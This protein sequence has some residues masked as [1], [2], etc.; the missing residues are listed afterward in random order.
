MYTATGDFIEHFNNEMGTSPKCPSPS[1]V[2]EDDRCIKKKFYK[3]WRI[4]TDISAC[5]DNEVFIQDK[6]Y[7]NINILK[8]NEVLKG[9][10]YLLSNNKEY[11]LLMQKDGHL[12]IYKNNKD[13]TDTVVWASKKWGNIKDKYKLI[14]QEDGNLVVYDETTPL[15]ASNTMQSDWNLKKKHY[16]LMLLDSGILVI[17][18]GSN[19]IWSSYKHIDNAWIDYGRNWSSSTQDECQQRCTNDINCVAYS[20]AAKYGKYKDCYLYDKLQGNKDGY[21]HNSNDNNI[22]KDYGFMVGIKHNIG[23]PCSDDNQCDSKM[24]CYNSGCGYKLGTIGQ[25][26]TYDSDCGKGEICSGH[27]GEGFKCQK[28]GKVGQACYSDSGCEPDLY[29]ASD[30]KCNFKRTKGNWCFKN[31]GCISNSCKEFKCN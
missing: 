28:I 24:K 6:C 11:Y 22:S 16:F 29:C 13:S 5:S 26:C 2:L 15:W 19:V 7:K 9:G 1:Y 21:R 12:V 31:S 17:Y 27:G 3:N 10:E 20:S 23:T 25:A 18:N 4:G 30:L 14:M 8:T